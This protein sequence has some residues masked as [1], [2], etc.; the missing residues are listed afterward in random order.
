MRLRSSLDDLLAGHVFGDSEVAAPAVAEERRFAA[1]P[2]AGVSL[3]ETLNSE[4]EAFVTG[5]LD[6]Y[7][8]RWYLAE[9]ST[10]VSFPSEVK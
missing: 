3:P 4:L 10:D 6:E 7:V 8:S 2:W 5:L 9:I 1:P